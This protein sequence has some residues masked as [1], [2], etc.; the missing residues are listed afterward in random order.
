MIAVFHW[1]VKYGG[2]FYPAGIGFPINPADKESL[3]VAGAKIILEEGELLAQEDEQP[4][5]DGETVKPKAT[6]KPRR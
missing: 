2:K 5:A 3:V 4:S 6:R 1:K